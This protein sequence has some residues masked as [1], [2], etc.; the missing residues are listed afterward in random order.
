MDALKITIEYCAVWHYTDKAVSLAANLL[1]QFESNIEQ[2]KLIPSSGG[3]YEIT[4]NGELLYSKLSTYRHANPG[5][6]E[7]LVQKFIREGKKWVKRKVEF[8]QVPVQQAGSI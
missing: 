3:R 8:F 7:Q 5:E 2:I 6:V 4:V 1:D